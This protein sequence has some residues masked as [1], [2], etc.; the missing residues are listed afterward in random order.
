MVVVD[1]SGGIVV[2]VV[3]ALSGSGGDTISREPRVM[4]PLRDGH[5]C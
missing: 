5:P 3:A 1:G 2:I 4:R